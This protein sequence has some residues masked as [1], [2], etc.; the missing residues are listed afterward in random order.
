[1]LGLVRESDLV[2]D[3][4]GA[5]DLG[6]L[7][8]TTRIEVSPYLRRR[9]ERDVQGKHVPVGHLI[10]GD[11]EGHPLALL[12]GYVLHGEDEQILVLRDSTNSGG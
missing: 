5:E 10:L 11:R 1:M 8:L 7:R 3:L 12:E 9:G 4:R 2:H 6:Q